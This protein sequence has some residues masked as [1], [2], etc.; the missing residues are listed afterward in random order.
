MPSGI[1][2]SRAHPGIIRPAD[3]SCPPCHHPENQAHG[4]YRPHPDVFIR[5]ALEPHPYPGADFVWLRRNPDGGGSALLKLAKGA[6]LPL[7][8]HPGTE[9]VFVT[10]GKLK[11]GEHVLNKGDH[12]FIDA[13]VPHTVEALQATV[14]L[15]LSETD[16]VELLEPGQTG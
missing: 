5:L 2:A 3:A 11:V 4:Q 6:K 1:H 9:Q 13:H 12:L 10:A 7:H 14:Y 8:Q 16:G 15:T